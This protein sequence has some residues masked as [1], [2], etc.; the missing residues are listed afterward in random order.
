MRFEPKLLAG[1]H[2]LA[3]IRL[4]KEQQD[5]QGCLEFI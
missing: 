3:A 1:E 5:V 2:R 4:L